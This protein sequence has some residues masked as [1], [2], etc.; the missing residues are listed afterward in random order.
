MI[1]INRERAIKYINLAIDLNE[2]KKMAEKIR[3]EALFSPIIS[4]IA[5]TF[6]LKDEKEYEQSI[7]EKRV[8]KHLEQTSELAAN[9]GYLKSEKDIEKKNEQLNENDIKSKEIENL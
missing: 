9:M 8:K 4:K 5:I 6:N 2:T 1:K 3:K 7:K